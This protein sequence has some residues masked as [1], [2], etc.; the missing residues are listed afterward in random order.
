[1]SHEDCDTTALKWFEVSLEFL[2]LILTFAL[3]LVVEYF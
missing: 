2:V 3:L 1:M